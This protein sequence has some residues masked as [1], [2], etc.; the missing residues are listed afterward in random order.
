[1]KLFE[2]AVIYTPNAEQKKAGAKPELVVPKTDILAENDGK[3]RFYA[4]RAV[5]KEWEERFEQLEILVRPF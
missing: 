3:A 5:P 1:M 2:F 4:S